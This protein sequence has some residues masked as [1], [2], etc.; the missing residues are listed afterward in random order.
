MQPSPFQYAMISSSSL[1][2]GFS[3]ILTVTLTL[4]VDTEVNSAIMV[5]IPSSEIVSDTT[6]P[7]YC[8]GLLGLST[9]K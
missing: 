9:T 3:S 6:K 4:S 7:F 8:K 5:T 1:I 2:N